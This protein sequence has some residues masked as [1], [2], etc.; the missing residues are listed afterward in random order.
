MSAISIVAMEDAMIEFIVS[1]DCEDFPDR[2]L[3]WEEKSVLAW[4]L[5]KK[6]TH[7][8]L[9]RIGEMFTD[10]VINYVEVTSIHHQIEDGKPVILLTCEGVLWGSFMNCSEVNGWFK[11]LPK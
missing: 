1:I 6:V 7:I 8:T 5:Y 11:T 9:P 3:T 4:T 10:G 2:T